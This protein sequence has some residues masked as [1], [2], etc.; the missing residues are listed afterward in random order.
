MGNSRRTQI[1]IGT[2]CRF[3]Q[4]LA[5]DNYFIYVEKDLNRIH[6]YNGVKL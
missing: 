6:F 3:T 5:G 1:I 2:N 4:V